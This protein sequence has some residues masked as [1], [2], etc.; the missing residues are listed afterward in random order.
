MRKAVSSLSTGSI[1][2]GAALILA[3]VAAQASVPLGTL[4]VTVSDPGAEITMS[5]DQS[6]VPTPISGPNTQ[7]FVS[8]DVPVWNFVASYGDQGPN[9]EVVYY[10]S[11][12]NGG[13]Q[14]SD[15]FA[16]G[17]YGAGEVPEQYYSGL[18]TGP[19][20]A[21]GTYYGIDYNGNPVTITFTAVPEAS[22]WAMM[23]LGFGGLG[24]AGYRASQKGSG[25]TA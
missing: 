19:I 17:V 20:F 3:P 8:T 9:P 25:L 15:N 16:F 12:N 23:L 14:T 1:V 4:L 24:L 7:D 6:S 10:P 18:E 5:W 13:F 22:T 21:P 2:L 11:D